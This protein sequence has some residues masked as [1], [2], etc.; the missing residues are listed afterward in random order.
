MTPVPPYTSASLYIDYTGPYNTHTLKF[1][2]AGGVTT[3]AAITKITPV[4]TAMLPFLWDGSTFATARWRAAGSSISNSVTFTPMT[5]TSGQNPTT[6][7]SP[8]RFLQWGGRNANGVRAKWYLFETFAA[9]KPNLRYNS[10]DS[11]GVDAVTAALV[12]AA[13]GANQLAAADGF[14]PTMYTYANVGENDYWTHQA[15]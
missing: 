13:A 3:A 7:S 9:L 6:T 1:D 12:T 8:A 10:G 5:S 2:F 14:S 15:R 11:A 4:L